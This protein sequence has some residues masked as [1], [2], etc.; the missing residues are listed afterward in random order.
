MK[1]ITTKPYLIRAIHE[2]CVDNGYTPYLSVA[3]NEFT[4]VPQEFV[5]AGEIVLNVSPVATNQLRLGNERV[6]FQARFGGVVRN[7]DVP[8]DQVVAIYAREN[9]H[10]MAFEVNKPLAEIEGNG[11]EAVQF[12]VQ[13]SDEPQ[14]EPFNSGEKT[15]KKPSQ[16]SKNHLTR[17]K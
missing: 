11:D 2:W 14:S 16:K 8:I 17:V 9:G 3:V 13:S 5:K 6:E 10:G 4:K 1:E 7:I 15:G 12:E